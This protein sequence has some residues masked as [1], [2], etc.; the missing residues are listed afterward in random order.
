[1]KSYCASDLFEVFHSGNFP[2]DVE[3]VPKKQLSEE[4][5]QKGIYLMFF[6]QQLIYVGLADKQPAISRFEK[7]L[8]TV[9]LRGRKVSFNQ[10]SQNEI[11]KSRGLSKC[12]N[13]ASL[14]RNKSGFQTSPRRIVFA[15]KNW[16]IFSRLDQALLNHFVFVLLLS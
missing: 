5:S 6:E 14:S 1:M 2:L 13:K 8:S 7:Q 11:K 10:E 9:T 12:F 16:N 3:F 15:E 4:L